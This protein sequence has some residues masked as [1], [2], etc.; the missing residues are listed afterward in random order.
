MKNMLKKIALT[1]IPALAMVSAS[2]AANVVFGSGESNSFSEEN[3]TDLA[4]GNL[5]RLGVFSL[6][7]AQIQANSG[8]V[9]F[10]NSNFTQ[11]GTARIGDSFGLPG[12]FL[13]SVQFDTTS[14]AG[15]QMALWVFKSANNSSDMASVNSALQ[16]GIFY[17]DKA[18]NSQ[19]TVPMQVPVP[20]ATVIDIA[21]LTTPASGNTQLRAGAHVVVGSF[22]NG[23]SDATEAPGFGLQTVSEPVPEP[24]TISFLGIAALGFLARRR[25][26]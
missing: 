8:N 15:R 4:V 6:T 12:H 21:D 24:S 26:N 17:M 10:L 19:W 5:A 3:G 11:I 13:Q 18:L 9:A 23:I 25:S 22:P 14:I 16:I 7:D 1:I 20:G 2:D